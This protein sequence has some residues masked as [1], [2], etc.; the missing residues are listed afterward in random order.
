M[1]ELT[2]EF[3]RQTSIDVCSATIRKALKKAGVTRVRS[4]R[5]AGVR[6]AVQGAA[7]QRYGYTAAPAGKLR[8]AA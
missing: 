8:L 4:P 6:A 3:V 2:R 1:D 5:R 7:P